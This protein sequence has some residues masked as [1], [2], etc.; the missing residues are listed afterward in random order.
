VLTLIVD[1]GEGDQRS[2]TRR[3]VPKE[4]SASV[5]VTACLLKDAKGYLRLAVAATL[6]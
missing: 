4:E 2:P 3:V 1:D 5:G 6:S